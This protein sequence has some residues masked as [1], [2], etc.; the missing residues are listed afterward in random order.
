[1]SIMNVVKWALFPSTL[2]AASG[3][4]VGTAGAG[5]AVALGAAW[6]PTVA[7][8]AATHVAAC[9][10]FNNSPSEVEKVKDR[11]RAYLAERKL[12]K[13]A[14]VDVETQ[15]VADDATP[16]PTAWEKMGARVARLA[17]E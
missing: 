15:P 11:M 7:V 8:G 10:V 12:I 2:K 9:T 13:E 1:M 3:A 5:V 17:G 6:V 14:L 4:L 16:A